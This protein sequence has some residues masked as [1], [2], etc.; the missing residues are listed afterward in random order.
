MQIAEGQV[1]SIQVSDELAIFILTV[2]IP[3]LFALIIPCC[4]KEKL[5][6][7][8]TSL[9]CNTM[10]YKSSLASF[11][12][13]AYILILLLQRLAFAAI[14]FGI[15]DSVIQICVMVLSNLVISQLIFKIDCIYLDRHLKAFELF[16][17]LMLSLAPVANLLF[18][19]FMYE[20]Y[21]MFDFGYYY[22]FTVWVYSM[23][24]LA[25]CG[26]YALCCVAMVC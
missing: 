2:T 4:R 23:L 10:F 20:R 11:W 16:N 5:L 3:L 18:S 25:I 21:M 7:R 13:K 8:R 17:Q 22:T 19:D 1:D 14:V 15:E 9:N 24:G 12:S 26:V 6:G